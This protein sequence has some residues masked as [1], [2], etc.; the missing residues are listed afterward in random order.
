[1]ALRALRSASALALLLGLSGY[2][3][4]NA[5]QT[6]ATS[7]PDQIPAVED[8]D[9]QTPGV[10]TGAQCKVERVVVTGSN[11]AGAAES[12]ALPVE[13]YTAEDNFKSGNQST[14]DFIKTLSVVGSTVGETNQFQAGYGGIGASTLN[15]RGLGGG[16]TLT[17]FNGRRFTVNTNQ[18]PSIALSRTEILKDGGAVIYGA[19]ATGGVVNFITRDNYDGLMVQGDYRAVSGSDGDWSA[20]LLWGKNFDQANLMFSAE[21]S[22]RSKLPILERDWAVRSY[23]DNPTPWA[24]YNTYGTYLLQSSTGSTV[25]APVQDF[26]TAECQNGTGPVQGQVIPLSGLPTCWWNYAIHTYNLVEEVDQARLYGQ[27]TADLDDS[28]RFT[29]TLAYGKS[30][31]NS[32]GTVASYQTNVGP[33]PGSGTAFEYRVPRS[34][35]YFNT[36]LAQNAAQ[37]NPAVLGLID[38]ADQFLT[39]GFG[40]GG[41][42]AWGAGQGTTPTT[43]LENWNAAAV[44]EGE[45]GDWAG[46]WLDTWK[47]SVTYNLSTTDST[48]PDIVGF[49]YQQALNGFG[50]PNCN[51]PDLV[52]DNFNIVADTD[53]NG[54]VSST[55]NRVWVEAFYATVGTQNPAQ[56]GKNGCQYINPFASSYA[57]NGAFGTPNPRYVAGNEIPADLAAWLYDER[58]IEDQNSELTIDALVSGGTPLKLP[59]GMVAWAAGAQWRQAE[60][61]DQNFGPYLDPQEFPCAWPGQQPGQAGCA[62]TGQS[63]YWFFASNNANKSD[64]QQYSYFGEMQVPVLDNLGFQLAVRREEFPRA[65]LGAT[66]YK[67][68]G[69][70]DPFNWLA[71]RGSFGTNYATPPN[72]QPGSISRGLSLIN[73]AGNKYLNVSTETLGGLKPE[74]AEVMNLGAIFNFDEGLPLNGRL[75]VSLDYFDFKIVDEIKT[76][77]HNQILNTAFVATPGSSGLINCSAALIGR[78]TFINGQGAAGCTQGVTIGQ[79]VTSI[80]SVRGNGP[81]ATTSGV[82]IDATYSF[83]ALGGDLSVGFQGTNVLGYEVSAFEL[84]GVTLSPKV[85]ALGFANYS[86]DGD[87]VSEWRSNATVNYSN[88][89]HN[90]RY[91]YRFIQGVEDDRSATP[92]QFKQIPDFVT[93]NLYY[94]YTLPWDENFVVSFAI[95]NV[96]DEDPPFTQQQ[97]SYDPF[98]GNAL[99][100]TFKIGLKKEF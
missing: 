66:V 70:W 58:K 64:Q 63:P 85:D 12:A 8:C 95:D 17:I 40:P 83:D 35:P 91:V 13:V 30:D 99:G 94:N 47:G 2:T 22:H 74:T 52:P 23:A 57:A 38:H 45:F 84:N 77:S 50:G 42:P 82:D 4:A 32:I 7:G 33:G 51:A 62:P 59:G 5:Q 14:M 9:L 97:Y 31:A 55:E 25:N 67:V 20:G 81:G 96:T 87:L 90:V 71:I 80:A 89:N 73:N 46:D 69:K 26:T 76:V 41:N 44:L 88:G 39:I 93:H 18:I 68:A 79:D 28:T 29:A 43:Q 36:F 3:T 34:N 60:S 48:L 65:G 49:K 54:V 24:P 78:L 1:M 53:R 11:I 86:R 75:R 98:I 16:R 6:P 27:F 61:R 92:V 72:T 19:D 37:I 56:A 15:L 100:R 10:Q 21:Y